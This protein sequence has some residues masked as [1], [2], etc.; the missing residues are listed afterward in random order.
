MSVV[1][2]SSAAYTSLC[3]SLKYL[4]KV[5]YIIQN[6]PS[7]VRFLNFKTLFLDRS[8]TLPYVWKNITEMNNICV[9]KDIASPKFHRICVL[10]ILTFWY[11][12]MLDVTASY[13][14]SLEF[15]AFFLGIFIHNWRSFM[16]DLLYLHQTFT[17]CVSD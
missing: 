15:I 10:L 1:C 2:S 3:R 17:S 9:W 5:S 4:L 16:S 13:G 7:I 6:Y 14:T 8:K 12:Y 11:I